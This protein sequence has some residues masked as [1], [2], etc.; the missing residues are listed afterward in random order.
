MS[1]SDKKSGRLGWVLAA[2][3]AIA[4]FMGVGPGTILANQ[5]T[6][7][8]GL[9]RLYVWGLFWCTVEAVI[10]VLAYLLVWKTDAEEENA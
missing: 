9:P 8:F 4:V 3:F 6:T 5:P 2:I 7:W 10:V 1:T